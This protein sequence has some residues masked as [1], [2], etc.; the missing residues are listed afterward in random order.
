MTIEQEIKVWV[1]FWGGFGILFSIFR[2]IHVIK[3]EKKWKKK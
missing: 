3:T 1:L 2:I